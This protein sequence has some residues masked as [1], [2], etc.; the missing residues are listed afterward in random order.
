MTNEIEKQVI[1]RGYRIGRTTNL[2][3]HYLLH[4]NEE[5]YNKSIPLGFEDKN[6]NNDKND[7]IQI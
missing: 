4:K 7:I 6:E 5:E 3:V 1:G 2:D